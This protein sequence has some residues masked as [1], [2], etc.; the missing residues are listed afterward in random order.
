MQ[1]WMDCR[2]G[3]QENCSCIQTMKI[4]ELIKHAREQAGL[5]QE[6]LADA[7]G[8]DKATVSRWETERRSPSCKTLVRI[9][10]ALG[11]TPARFFPSTGAELDLSGL[12][13]DTI[14]E[15]QEFEEFKRCRK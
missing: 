11:T 7:L 6:Q 1:Y 12:P 13:E 8:T 4:S 2:A 3:M 5:T 14:R 15:I 9:W 10:D